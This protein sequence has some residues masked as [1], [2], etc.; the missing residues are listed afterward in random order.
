MVT[1]VGTALVFDA[2]FQCRPISARFHFETQTKEH[3]RGIFASFISSSPYNIITDTAILV[4]PIPLLT[5]MRMPTREKMI[6]VVTFGVAI[7]VIG[8]DIIRIAFLEGTATARL[9]DLRT[10]KVEEIPNDDYTC[11]LTPAIK[12]FSLETKLSKAM[13][14][15][16]RVRC[17]IVH[18]VC[19]RGEHNHNLCLCSEHEASC[20]SIKIDSS[21][22]W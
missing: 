1:V 10:S 17:N 11:L 19:G 18:V 2:I 4:I 3:C 7:C 6:L 12:S 20:N 13:L 9:R 22:A 21:P 8:V 14:I 5:R 16:H 15:S